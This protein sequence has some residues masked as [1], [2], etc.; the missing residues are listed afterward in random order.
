M[1]CR[2]HGVQL[3]NAAHFHGQQEGERT[4][5]A[6]RRQSRQAVRLAKTPRHRPEAV[7]THSRPACEGRVQVH[8]RS[9]PRSRHRPEDAGETAAVCHHR[10]RPG[11]RVVRSRVIVMKKWLRRFLIVAPVIAL[12]LG[13]YFEISTQLRCAAG[14]GTARHSSM[15]GRPPTGARTSS[16]I[17]RPIRW[18][19]S[20]ARSRRH[21]EP[22]SIDSRGL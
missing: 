2:V 4:D 22:G 16:K 18:S 10:G 15:V 1:K 19:S 3:R 7:A 9:T 5:G 17:C 11:H 12:M 14:Y 8:R 13:V 6:D 20:P 21:R